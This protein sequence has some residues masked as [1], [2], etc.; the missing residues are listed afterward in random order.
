MVA[1]GGA[2]VLLRP[3]GLDLVPPCPLRSLTGLDC[4]L[5]GA[6]RATRALVLDRDLAA[7]ADLNALYV[8]GLFVAAVAAASWLRNRRAPAWLTHRRTPAVLAAIGVAF[9][10][11][12]NLPMVPFQYLGT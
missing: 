5:C 8:A 4:P 11:L 3:R 9:G 6:T 1:I 12:R 2:A 7:A 10:V